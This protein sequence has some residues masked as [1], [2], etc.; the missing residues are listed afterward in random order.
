MI[1]RL[2]MVVGAICLFAANANSTEEVIGNSYLWKDKIPPGNY[3]F[4]REFN[5]QYTFLD[6][7][8]VLVHKYHYAD[9][10]RITHAS[11]SHFSWK[12]QENG[13]IV[14]RYWRNSKG[15]ETYLD[16]YYDFSGDGLEIRKRVS[17]NGQ[18]VRDIKNVEESLNYFAQT[19]DVA[20]AIFKDWYD[21]QGERRV[22]WD[23]EE[24]KAKVVK[25]HPRNF[26][27]FN[28]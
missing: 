17:H 26:V 2:L 23:M 9:T 7:N 16:Y 12:S 19:P 22:Y 6:N 8:Q 10:G 13:I 24:Y 25:V 4:E 21:G 11:M 5:W 18:E 28:N 1:N 3:S 15:G 20:D 14:Q 27:S